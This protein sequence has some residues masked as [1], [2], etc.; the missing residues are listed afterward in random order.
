VR[1]SRHCQAGLPP[2]LQD[3]ATVF[4]SAPDGPIEFYENG[5]L[6]HADIERGQKTG[7]FLDQRDNRQ[8]IG[9]RCNDASVLDVF[10]NTGGFSVYACAGGARSVHSV[11]VS[12]HAIGATRRH[13]E[14]NRSGLGFRTRHTAAVADAFDAMADLADQRQRFDVV[15]VDPPSF[16]PNSSAI[17]AAQRAYQRLTS[18]A[19]EVLA[20]GGTL[21]QAS[22]SS[23]LGAN[24]FYDLV[25]D[26][27]DYNA[28]RATNT[29][30]TGHAIDHPIGFSQGAY[31]K[32]IITD[33]IPE[34]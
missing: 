2:A 16:A 19:L 31:L 10:C 28:Q 18:L 13:V 14:L 12:R 30:R 8:L 27:I 23:R 1:A 17:P 6:F 9:E 21:L 25:L 15:V 5:L 11:D 4:G 34:R 24:E 7:H 3:S 29:I 22:C 20:P 32:A 26:E 33:V